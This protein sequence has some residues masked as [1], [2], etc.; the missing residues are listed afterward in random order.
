MVSKGLGANLQTL[1]REKP[2]VQEEEG[3]RVYG[4]GH[5]H[6]PALVASG[7]VSLSVF[8]PAILSSGAHCATLTH[9][10]QGGKKVS[11][12][13]LVNNGNNVCCHSIFHK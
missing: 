10:K 5:S 6:P 12:G 1:A 4:V 7:A 11:R 3:Q 2:V 8:V 9:P 13:T